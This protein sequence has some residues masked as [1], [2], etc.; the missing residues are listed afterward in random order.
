MWMQ[1]ATLP[2]MFTV[3]I[4]KQNIVKQINIIGMHRFGAS[5]ISTCH[6]VVNWMAVMSYPTDTI[7]VHTSKSN[8]FC[9]QLSPRY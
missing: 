3:F 5:S 2:T 1:K 8:A 7:S 9:L 6:M 4:C